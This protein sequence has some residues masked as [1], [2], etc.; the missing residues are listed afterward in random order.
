KGKGK[1]EAPAQDSD[2]FKALAIIVVP[3]GVI[4]E[5]NTLTS[6]QARVP[7]REGIQTLVG[8]GLVVLNQN[9]FDLCRTWTH[10]QL[11]DFLYSVLPNVFGYF[12]DLEV[13]APE[14]G[15]QWLLGIQNRTKLKVAPNSRPT[16][17]DV[18]FNAVQSR[19]SWRNVQI[20]IC[21]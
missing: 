21:V 12:K 18:E 10:A 9:G 15:P 4:V 14:M 11:A 1:S 13:E 6:V 20:L 16:A 2:M 5:N 19:T 7:D 8:R 3:D 17:F